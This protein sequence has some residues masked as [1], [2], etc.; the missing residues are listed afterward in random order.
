[1][2]GSS[3]TEDGSDIL[4]PGYVDAVTNLAINLL[5]V[6]AIMSIVVLG[7]TLQIAELSKRRATE[8]DVIT[9]TTAVGAETKTLAQLEARLTN[10][11]EQLRAAEEKLR[12]AQ[13]KIALSVTPTN[14][15]QAKT[16]DV[17]AQSAPVPRAG[18][19]HEIDANALV[20]KFATESVVMGEGEIQ[21]LLAKVDPLKVNHRRWN[22]TV[23]SPRGFSEAS[24]TAYYRAHAVRNAL[25]Q[26]G[27][28]STAIDLRIL[29]STQSGAD[30]TQVL[31]KPLP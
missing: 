2:S 7:A 26:G 19:V 9:H 10:T 21:Q 24:R 29:E 5:F 25:L 3:N 8:G 23:I 28:A 18:G 11:T 20:V 31:V 14:S 22:I 27:I 4:W 16:I 17:A 13:E 12:L 1:M 15:Q 30:N 6:I